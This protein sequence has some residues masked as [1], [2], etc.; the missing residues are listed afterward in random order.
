MAGDK[1][2][3]PGAGFGGRG[4]W[5]IDREEGKD[6]GQ[7]KLGGVTERHPTS[8]CSSHWR[9]QKVWLAMRTIPALARTSST[10]A[11]MAE[12]SACLFLCVCNK[13][14]AMF[15]PLKWSCGLHSY[16]TL[17]ATT[18][19]FCRPTVE[20]GGAPCSCILEAPGTSVN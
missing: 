20:G 17:Q 3:G 14:H 6:L 13:R 7:A 16:G 5:R 2:K 19:F 12:H 4:L 8:G 9:T 18:T 1:S 11:D 10:S 15:S